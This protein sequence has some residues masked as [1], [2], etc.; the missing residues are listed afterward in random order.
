M[1]RNCLHVIIPAPNFANSRTPRIYFC[2]IDKNYVPYAREKVIG[3][4]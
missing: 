4:G 1:M 3:I 2:G